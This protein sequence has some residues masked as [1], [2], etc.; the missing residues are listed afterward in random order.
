MSF[1]HVSGLCARNY[2]P[3]T[4]IWKENYSAEHRRL[5]SEVRFPSK[6]RSRVVGSGKRIV[7]PKIK[8]HKTFAL[9]EQ[10]ACGFF[11]KQG[12][13]RTAGGVCRT[14]VVI[15]LLNTLHNPPTC[16]RRR[17]FSVYIN[18]YLDEESTIDDSLLVCTKHITHGLRS[19]RL[20]FLC[21]LAGDAK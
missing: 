20:V 2:T 14:R 7:F 3:K 4:S 5:R 13:C 10:S 1:T 19:D 16:L 11:S 9:R 15:A 21:E 8:R 18:C 6:V 17:R 12:F